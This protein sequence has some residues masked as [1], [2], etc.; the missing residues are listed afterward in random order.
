ML[1]TIGQILKPRG[2]KGE[3][4]VEILYNRPAVF[5]DLAEVFINDTK[6]AVTKSSVQ[7]G[8]A[9]VNLRGIDTIEKAEPFR[10]KEIQVR[11][12]NLHLADDEV[13][14]TDLIGFAV[15]HNGQNIGRINAVENYGAGDVFEIAVT[16]QGFVQ[17]PNEDDF[18]LETNMT[19][20]TLT[21]TPNALQ[22][23]IIWNVALDNFIV[24]SGNVCAVR[25]QYY[26]AGGQG[27]ED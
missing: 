13:L 9:Y 15:V 6:Y 11:A 7:N 26:R 25:K 14:S 4:K 17:I 10:N 1:V 20:K 21:L 23:E 18:I 16:G 24:V 3:L 5:N 19:Q 2:L 22:T 12:E 27:R 8:F